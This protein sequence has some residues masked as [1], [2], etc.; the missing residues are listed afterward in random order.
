M[1]AKKNGPDR[2]NTVGVT[3]LRNMYLPPILHMIRRY[4]KDNRSA[5]FL[6][7]HVGNARL[8]RALAEI[9]DEC[10]ATILSSVRIPCYRTN[11][12]E[13][14]KEMT[15]PF[16]SEVPLA[17]QISK[18][19]FCPSGMKV[20]IQR[21]VI[22]HQYSRHRLRRSSSLSV[23]LSTSA[24]RSHQNTRPGEPFLHLRG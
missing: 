22:S 19:R 18:M 13:R 12:E 5:A 1:D 3:T 4:Q 6:F 2:V 15:R 14:L 24:Q 7:G 17:S 10:Q 9:D 16:R 20:A 23:S 11:P 8:P 21:Q